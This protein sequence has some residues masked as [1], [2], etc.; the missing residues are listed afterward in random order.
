MVPLFYL[1]KRIE[2]K[3]FGRQYERVLNH[4]KRPKYQNGPLKAPVQV[5]MCQQISMTA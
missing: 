5:V 3:K 2:I 4:G 1:I